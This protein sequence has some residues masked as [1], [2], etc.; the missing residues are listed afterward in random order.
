MFMHD[1]ISSPLF[2]IIIGVYNDWAPLDRCLRSLSQQISA[3]SFEV[4]VVDDGSR[5]ANPEFI[6][7]WRSCYPLT[8]IRQSHAGVSVA[9]NRG[10]QTSQGSILL[11]VDADCRLE[12]NCL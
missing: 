10:I 4:I 1:P 3:P 6:H 8:L 9:R 7:H 5:E 2:S 11:F 12:T